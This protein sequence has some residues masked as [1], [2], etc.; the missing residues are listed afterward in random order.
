MSIPLDSHLFIL[1]FLHLSIPP[2]LHPCS[3]R[4]LPQLES[5]L[6]SC[7]SP[8]PEFPNWTLP[9]RPAALQEAL[10]VLPDLSR[11]LDLPGAPSPNPVF[12]I[13]YCGSGRAQTLISLG[14][15]EAGLGCTRAPAGLRPSSAQGRALLGLQGSSWREFLPWAHRRESSAWAGPALCNPLH[16]APSRSCRNRALLGSPEGHPGS[17]R[18]S[19]KLDIP[20]PAVFPASLRGG[21]G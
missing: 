4:V 20:L 16:V 13:Q 3:D 12:R 10:C 15:P 9:W 8:D 2:S 11:A 7:R 1:P 14:V 21:L 19:H 5:H 18:R 6:C 17:C